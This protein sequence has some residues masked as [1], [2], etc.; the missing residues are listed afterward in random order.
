MKTA[1]SKTTSSAASTAAKTQ[2]APFFSKEAQGESAFFGGETAEAELFFSPRT[3]QPKLTIGKPNDKYEQQ[4]DAVADQVVA[5]LNSPTPSPPTPKGSTIAAQT[6]NGRNTQTAI[7]NKQSAISNPSTPPVQAKC[8]HCEQ[9]EKLQKKDE[10]IGHVGEQVQMKPIFDSAAEPPPDDN[11]QRKTDGNTEGEASSDFSSQLSSSKGGGT[12]LPADTQEK[13]GSTIGADFSGVRIHTGSEA[14]KMSNDIGAQAFTHGNNVYFNEGKYNPSSTEGSHLLAHEL[15][16]TVQQGA[17]VKRKVTVTP[18]P[19]VEKTTSTPA[20]I[21]TTT[22]TATPAVVQTKSDAGEGEEKLQKKEEE[23][24]SLGGEEVHRKPIF[25]SNADPMAADGLSK[26]II[27]NA[28]GDGDTLQR[29][30]NI[31]VSTAAPNIQALSFQEI[32]AAGGSMLNSAAQHVRGYTLFTVIIENNPLTGEHVPRTAQNL[33][34]E[35]LKLLPYGEDIYSKL[36]ENAI[37][38]RPK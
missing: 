21:H 14:A 32:A 38:G 12:S 33:V 27:G 1:E 37:I 20:A 4:A 35:L 26:P 3:L 28:G 2:N 7:N 18:P 10:E 13:M 11:V 23:I 6:S 19:S 24:S 34:R 17:A 9:E 15:T 31:T 36:N 5:K 22:P 25:D 16:H 30:E 8:D 29:T